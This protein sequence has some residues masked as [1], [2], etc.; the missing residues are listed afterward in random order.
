MLSFDVHISQSFFISNLS[1]FLWGLLAIVHIYFTFTQSLKYRCIK[2]V[3]LVKVALGIGLFTVITKINYGAPK[4]YIALLPPN[5][6]MNG[7]ELN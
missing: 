5:S 2:H 1:L 6:C 3:W 4:I 7:M